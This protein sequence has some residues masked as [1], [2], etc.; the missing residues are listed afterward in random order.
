M[1]SRRSAQQ[2]EGES[3]VLTKAF[4]YAD[5]LRFLLKTYL[6]EG[7]PSASMA[8]SLMDTSVRTM[9]RRLSECGVSYQAVVDEVRFDAAREL[10][11]D[12]DQSIGSISRSVG[13][14]DPAHFTRMF[15]RIAGLSPRQLRY[16]TNSATPVAS[17]REHRFTSVVA[18]SALPWFD[19]KTARYISLRSP[20]ASRLQR[21]SR[22]SL[23]FRPPCLRPSSVSRDR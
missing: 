17:S 22:L 18:S 14:D 5:T 1:P 3:L 13:F 4:N 2:Q 10:L 16:Q 7:Y 20:W 23:R 15:R 9:A 11:R 21:S 6:A 8:A 19:V 12:P